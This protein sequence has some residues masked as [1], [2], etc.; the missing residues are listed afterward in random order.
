MQGGIGSEYSGLVWRGFERNKGRGRK[1]EEGRGEGGMSDEIER[2][3]DNLN[4]IG[5]SVIL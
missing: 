3:N 1:C 2:R 5:A 4:T